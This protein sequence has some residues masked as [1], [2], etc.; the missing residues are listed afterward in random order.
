MKQG[1]SATRIKQLREN[2]GLSLNKLSALSGVSTDYIWR[3]ESGQTTNV[4][5]EKLKAIAAALNVSVHALI[6]DNFQR[7]G[8]Q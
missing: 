6:D 4:G 1:S 7:A 5:I 2:A 3:I 8:H